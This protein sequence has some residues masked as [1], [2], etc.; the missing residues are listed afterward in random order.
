VKVKIERNLELIEFA[1]TGA[2]IVIISSLIIVYCNEKE[3]IEVRLI[4]PLMSLVSIAILLGLSY[5]YSE[6]SL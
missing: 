1:S 4:D 2:V 5:P 3:S 6:F